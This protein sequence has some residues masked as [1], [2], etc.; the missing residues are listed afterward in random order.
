[1]F[2]SLAWFSGDNNLSCLVFTVFGLLPEPNMVPVVLCCVFQKI[3][4]I[5]CWQAPT[6][7]SE[8]GGQA[9]DGLS[10]G[11]EVVLD[12]VAVQPLSGGPTEGHQ[13]PAHCTY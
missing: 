8:A 13:A 10:C 5:F 12:Q 1:M 11:S 7:G 3:F 6:F 4:G 9:G 2:P